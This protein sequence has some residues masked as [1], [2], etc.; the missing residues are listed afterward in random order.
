[1]FF[2]TVYSNR[3]NRVCEFSLVNTCTH[4]FEMICHSYLSRYK[5]FNYMYVHIEKPNVLYMNED[6][7]FSFVFFPCYIIFKCTCS[8]F[9]TYFLLKK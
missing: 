1:M 2:V 6:L 3:H 4:L 9:V 8:K 7:F 5:L